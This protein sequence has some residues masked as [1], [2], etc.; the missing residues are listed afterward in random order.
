MIKNKSNVK[1]NNSNT[2]DIEFKDKNYSYSLIKKLDESDEDINQL[3]NNHN[4][5][6]KNVYDLNI[7]TNE[8]KLYRDFVRSKQL[9]NQIIEELNDLKNKYHSLEQKYNELNILSQE[10]HNMNKLSISESSL[11]KLLLEANS[12]D[13]VSKAGN[14]ILEDA[15]KRMSFLKN[16]ILEIT[17]L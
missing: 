3:D 17:R 1:K 10:T 5:D 16:D 6:H 7:N 12:L 9:N 2:Y 8:I 15:D 14:N 11:I 4:T 13:A